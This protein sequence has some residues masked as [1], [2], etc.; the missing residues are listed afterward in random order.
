MDSEVFCEWLE[1]VFIPGVEA[2][3]VKKPVL[4][5]VDGHSTHVNMKASDMCLKHGVELYCLLEH[6]SHVIQPLDLRL[7]SA[8]KRNLKQAVQDFQ[9]EHIGE[10]VTKTP[11]A[12]VFKQAWN[13]STTV[14]DAVKGFQEAGLFPL[15]PAAVMSSMQIEPSKIFCPHKPI[16]SSECNRKG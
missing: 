4:L 15:N 7:F 1:N 16:E 8:F 3:N 5:L 14:E 11:F 9:S 13:A 12:G 10:Y 2:R 6:A